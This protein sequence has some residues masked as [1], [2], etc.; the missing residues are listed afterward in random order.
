[1][2]LCT[3]LN[4]TMLLLAMF[5]WVAL[6]L[7][8]SPSLPVQIH[9]ITSIHAYQQTQGSTPVRAVAEKRWIKEKQRARLALLRTLR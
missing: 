3:R 9:S 8:Q 1:M 7:N 5:L 2:K 4:L 6:L